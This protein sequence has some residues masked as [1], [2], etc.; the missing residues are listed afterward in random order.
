MQI[1]EGAGLCDIP[2]V[3]VLEEN[4]VVMRCSL[5]QLESA[6]V[7]WRISREKQVFLASSAENPESEK[8]SLAPSSAV[9]V[10]ESLL[11]QNLFNTLD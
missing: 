4:S 2:S 9:Q 10:Q 7:D 11:L 5:L 1:E 8:D 6:S 3:R